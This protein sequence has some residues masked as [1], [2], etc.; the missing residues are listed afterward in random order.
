MFSFIFL[1]II[2]H[3]NTFVLNIPHVKTRSVR[4]PSL[5]PFM[6]QIQLY[7]SHRDLSE[8]K[9]VID[10]FYEG[11]EGRLEDDN[12]VL[13]MAAQQFDDLRGELSST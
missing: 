7:L 10:S 13:E 5:I 8:Q 9:P 1:L 2:T 6:G 3:T 11:D 12:L 4:H